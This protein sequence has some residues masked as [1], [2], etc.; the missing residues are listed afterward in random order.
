[1]RSKVAD[2]GGLRSSIEDLRAEP[3][4]S[5]LERTRAARELAWALALAFEDSSSPPSDQPKAILIR[6]DARLRAQLESQLRKR[7][8]MAN[9]AAFGAIIV[10]LAV[11]N[12]VLYSLS[13]TITNTLSHYLIY[14]VFGA[15][16][17]FLSVIM[18]IRSIEVKLDLKK[19]EYIFAGA[20]RILIGVIG[21]FVVGLSLDSGLIDPTFG[22]SPSHVVA[23]NV[24]N[25]DKHLAMYLIFSFIAGFS[26]S[27][28]PSILRR[29][30]QATN[31][32]GKTATPDD[33]IVKEMKP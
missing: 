25:L 7:Y 23:S 32:N 19:W 8:A 16:G 29:G 1:L 9:L 33:P 31:G 20:T 13:S 18:G 17:A 24:S 26:E 14:G 10:I 6:V 30:E 4:F 11:S 5:P 22:S 27:L 12:A 21:A 15:L 28:V 3:S 2:L